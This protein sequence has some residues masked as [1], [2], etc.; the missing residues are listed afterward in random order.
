M[1]DVEKQKATEAFKKYRYNTDV[2]LVF[3]KA[4]I[5]WPAVK[6]WSLDFFAT[7]YG[8]QDVTIN[9]NP[10]LIDKKSSQ[11]F[12]KLQLNQYISLLKEGSLNYL[13]FS[14]L[15]QEEKKLQDDLDLEWLRKFHM[16][17]SFGELFYL[18]IGG[19]GTITPV[20]DGFAGTLFVQ[21]SGRKKWIL[22]PTRDRIFLDPRPT[23]SSYF[24]SKANP[25]NLEDPDFPLLKYARKCEITIEPGD[26]LWV[27]PFMWHQVENLDH[28]IGLAYKFANL[29]VALMSSKVLTALWLMAT[30]P[31]IL[32]SYITK[33]F[34]RRDIELSKPQA[35][36]T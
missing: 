27:P 13:K 26:I 2:P 24:Y 25:Y 30:N 21:I 14:R 15:V 16:P 18:F 10:G 8:S 11:N 29:P 3:R 28:S 1:K 22:Y 20:H 19:K 32:H 4:A 31:N 9:D 7:Y 6:K 36:L 17:A 33:L 12:E 23:R 35:H 34:Q 5:D